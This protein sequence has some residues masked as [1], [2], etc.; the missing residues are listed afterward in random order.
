[1]KFVRCLIPLACAAVLAGCG[2]EVVRAPLPTMEEK[3]GMQAS[4]REKR[5]QQ[6]AQKETYRSPGEIAAQNQSEARKGIR[7]AKLLRGSPNRKEVALTFDDGPHGGHTERLLDILKKQNVKA[8]FFVV[9]KMAEAHPELVMREAREGHLVANHTYTHLNLSFIPEEEIPMQYRAC[10]D[11]I[12]SL[13]TQRPKF[14][15]PPGGQYDDVVMKA[16]ADCGL[17]TVLWTDDPGDYARPGDGAI[18]QRVLQNIGNGSIVLLHDGVQQTL[19][20]LPRLIESLKSR[21][22]TFVTV[23]QMYASRK[24]YEANIAAQRRKASGVKAMGR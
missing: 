14:C 20:C 11:L 7:Y 1:M 6:R 5:M 24:T 17:V 12:F 13:T 16:A 18:Q 8:T 10:S 15:R 2:A 4:L 23:D 9:G 22:Y 19:D 21:G 3:R